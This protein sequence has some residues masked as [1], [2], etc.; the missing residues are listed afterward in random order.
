MGGTSTGSSRSGSPRSARAIGLGA[1]A[2]GPGVSAVVGTA[3]DAAGHVLGR[4]LADAEDDAADG[5]DRWADLAA[6]RLAYLWIR[7]LHAAGLLDAE[8]PPGVLVD[9]ALPP[10]DDLVGWLLEQG[11]P[12]WEVTTVLQQFDESTGGVVDSD[13]GAVL[14]AMRAAQG[15]FYDELG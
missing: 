12:G 3:A 4:S 14:D 2:F 11:P 8:L 9:G 6:E 7:E 5:H 10:Y 1:K 15:R 13:L